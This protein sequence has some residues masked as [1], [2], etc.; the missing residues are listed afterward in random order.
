MLRALVIIKVVGIAAVLFLSGCG[1]PEPSAPIV[2]FSPFVWGEEPT[3]RDGKDYRVRWLQQRS[4][5]TIQNGRTPRTVKIGLR[6]ATLRTPRNVGLEQAGQVLPIRQTVHKSFWE[7]GDVLIEN[8]ATLRSGKNPFAIVADGSPDEL[9]PG[10]L[11]FLLLV[12][13]IEVSDPYRLG[14][15]VNIGTSNFS[16]TELDFIHKARFTRGVKFAGSRCSEGPS[17]RSPDTICATRCEI[18]R[19]IL[20]HCRHVPVSK[21]DERK[22]ENLAFIGACHV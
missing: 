13:G 21:R 19:N 12:G 6:V 17:N 16:E 14:C 9:S 18:P 10:R 11:I 22:S 1:Q 7:G 2:Q 5:F 3:T 20:W 8:T 15:L 4:E